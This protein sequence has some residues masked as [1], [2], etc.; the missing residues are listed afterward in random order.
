[1]QSRAVALAQTRAQ[2]AALG[3]QVAA[4]RGQLAE[5]AATHAKA[6]STLA[7]VIAAV[8]QRSPKNRG[9]GGVPKT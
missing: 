8:A 5:E 4:V 3:E 6:R 9:E 2:E 7:Q 1:L